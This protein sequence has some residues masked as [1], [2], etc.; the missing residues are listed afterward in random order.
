MLEQFSNQVRECYDRAAEARA[1]ADATDDP[2]LKAELLNAERRWLGL[3]CGFGFTESF[4]DFTTGNSEKR[5]KV[6]E[7]LEANIGSAPE[8]SLPGSAE[9]ILWSIVVSSNDSIIIE[10][11][12][13]IISSCN[14]AAERL[15]G[16]TA[17]EAV[18]KPVTILIPLERHGEEPTILARIGHGE[19]IDHYETVRQRK[20]GSLIDIS[21]TVSPIKNAQGKIVGAAK[22]ARDITDRKRNDEH[23]T[24]LAR[25]AEHRTLRRALGDCAARRFF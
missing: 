17:E 9:H 10:N 25:E 14:K 6:D 5:H 11:L 4:E 16:Y 21:L 7:P 2:T 19:R 1:K 20:D 22:I 12:D 23:I 15:F 18:G 13:G 8:T 24:M 3:A